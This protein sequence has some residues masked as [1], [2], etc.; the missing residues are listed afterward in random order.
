MADLDALLE[1]WIDDVQL[2]TLDV[3]KSDSDDSSS[4]F[5]EHIL[6]LERVLERATLANLGFKLDKC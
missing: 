6:A 4:G 1:I 3:A 2:G 5:D